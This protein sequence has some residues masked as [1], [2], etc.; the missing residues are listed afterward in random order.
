[1]KTARL[2]LLVLA[3]ATLGSSKCDREGRSDRPCHADG[4]ERF[5]LYVDGVLM[6]LF[7]GATVRGGRLE[8]TNGILPAGSYFADWREFNENGPGVTEKHDLTVY[9]Y[10][11]GG[12]LGDALTEAVGSTLAEF[13]GARS[14]DDPGCLIV[15]RLA[16]RFERVEG[17]TGILTGGR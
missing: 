3:L 4:S 11:A 9:E 2:S 13:E 16:T 6:G 7:E 8:L 12:R 17:A 5:A 14:L 15:R 10:R 1:M